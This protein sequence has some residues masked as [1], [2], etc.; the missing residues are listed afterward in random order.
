MSRTGL[1]GR[2]GTAVL[3]TC[4]SLRVSGLT[5]LVIRCASLVYRTGHSGSYST[6]RTIPDSKP[7]GEIMGRGLTA[8]DRS[9][10]TRR[11]SR[12]L[13]MSNGVGEI[14]THGTLVRYAGFQDRCIQ[15]LCHHA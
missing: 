8:E 5:I 9:G 6:S 3:P 2:P 10:P 1:D 11:G 15:P 13:A 12:V 14:R 7:R 4:S